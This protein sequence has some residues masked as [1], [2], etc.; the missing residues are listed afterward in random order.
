MKSDDATMTAFAQYLI[1][2]VQA[3]AQQGI[4]IEA[5]SP[6]N[7]P[8]YTGTYPTCGW[9]PATYTKFVGQHLGPAVAGA[10]LATKIM[11]GTFNGGGSDAIDRRQRDGRRHRARPHRACSAISGA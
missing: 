3:Y 10:G 1:K 7:E 2:F 5:I 9:S 6:Q 11:L 4:A 8:N